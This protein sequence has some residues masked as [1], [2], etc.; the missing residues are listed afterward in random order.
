MKTK[1]TWASEHI[2][3]REYSWKMVFIKSLFEQN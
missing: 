3:Y 1:D 2:I